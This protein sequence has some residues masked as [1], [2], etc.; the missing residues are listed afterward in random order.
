MSTLSMESFPRGDFESPEFL[1]SSA[2]YV[3]AT[4][5]ARS[6]LLCFSLDDLD[7]KYVRLFPR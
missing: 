6:L 4:E 7:G 3:T 1:R 2:A 5:L